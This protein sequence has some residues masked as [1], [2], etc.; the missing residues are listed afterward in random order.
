MDVAQTGWVNHVKTLCHVC[1]I[2]FDVVVGSWSVALDVAYFSTC[3][4]DIG[5]L[6]H[7]MR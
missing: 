6:L 5:L 3:L 1:M 2:L 4:G 7:V